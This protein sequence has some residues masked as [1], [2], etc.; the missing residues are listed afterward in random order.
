MEPNTILSLLS[1]GGLYILAPIGAYLMWTLQRK[2]AAFE[3]LFERMNEMEQNKVV[4]GIILGHIEDDISEIKQ[5]I[6]KLVE[7]RHKG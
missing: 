4:H 1:T 2:H 7:L 3:R 6:S 5:S